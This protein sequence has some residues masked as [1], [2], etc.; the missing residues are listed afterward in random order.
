VGDVGGRTVSDWIC[1]RSRPGVA[2]TPPRPVVATVVV[3]GEALVVV[4]GA[5]DRFSWPDLEVGLIQSLAAGGR[6]VVLDARQMPFVDATVVSRLASFGRR[7]LADSGG[8]RVVSA[9]P[10]LHRLVDLLLIGDALV[11]EPRS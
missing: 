4:V 8:L 5:V 9:P 1:G 6:R 11:V 10:V 7:L 3:D 2:S